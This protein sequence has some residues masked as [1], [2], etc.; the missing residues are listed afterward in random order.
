MPQA[1]IPG[2]SGVARTRP[3]VWG[4]FECTVLRTRAGWRDQMRETGHYARI[5]DLDAAA[6]LGLRTMRYPVLLE[7]VAPDRP[8]DCDWTWHDERLTHLRRLGIAPIAGLIHHGG[9]PEYTSLLDPAF[10]ALV[11]KHAER[12]AQRY[13]WIESWT[14]INEPLTTAR[15]SGLYGHWFPYINDFRTFLRMVV[16]QCRAVLLSMRA[17]RRVI[18]QARLVQTEDLGYT[19]ATPQLAYQAAHENERRWLSLDLLCG[20]VTPAHGW[21]HYLIDAGVPEAQLMDFLAGDLQPMVIGLNYYITSE[22][23]L[24]HRTALYPSHFHGGNGRQSYA[25]IEAVRVPLL[26][27]EET[28]WE[29][30]LLEAWNRY[31]PIPLAVTE[32]HIGWCADDEQVRWLMEAWQ[33]II[34]LRER[35]VDLQAITI[36]SLCGAMDWNSLLTRREGYYEP[37]ALGPL[38]ADGIPRPTLMAT[39]ASSL[40][41][42]GDFH[43]PMLARPGWWHRDDRFLPS[44]LPIAA[45]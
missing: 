15:F 24:D 32:A 33:A 16:N 3:E 30:R 35:G 2:I 5:S 12:A 22:R 41:R 31:D 42:H 17:I 43:A 13:P 7:H 8:D 20:R 4:G 25:D 14:P 19:F 6:A 28:G 23:Y 11:A 10:P 44:L 18:P 29:S 40:V 26:P 34:R 27:E 9:G 39:A 45:Q 37:G 21:W 38:H 36:W 1:E